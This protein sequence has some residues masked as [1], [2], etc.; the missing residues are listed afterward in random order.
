VAR[1]DQKPVR[2]GGDTVVK[3]RVGLALTALLAGCSLQQTSTAQLPATISNV[4]VQPAVF[5]H[6]LTFRYV[7]KAQAF[8][9]PA[10]TTQLSII[11]IGGRGGGIASSYGGRVSALIPVRSGETLEIRVGGN[12]QHVDGGF[13]GGGK[14][15]YY[16][17]SDDKRNGYGGGGATDIRE[18]G[19][20]LKDRVLVVGGG[21]GQGG[22][23]DVQSYPRFGVGGQG[24]NLIGGVGEAGYPQ[25]N[26]YDC[27]NITGCGGRGGTQG[28]GGDGGSGGSGDCT[29][30]TGSV[31]SPGLGGRGATANGSKSYDCGGLGGGGGAGYY[32]GGG[33]GQ[34]ASLNSNTV[35]GGGG[36]GG[37]SSY[38]EKSATDVHMWSGWIKNPYGLVVIRW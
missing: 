27:F 12:G 33:G 2:I 6:H 23:D 29:G 3:A 1:L 30:G 34:G 24:G 22:G 19:N 9:V 10:K 38:V 16:G 18:N 15:G 31:G 13:N 26:T 25:Y 35:G 17:F 4:P 20:M 7:G 11:A 37:G 5:P 8:R 14:G 36:G 28:S 32:G 21:G